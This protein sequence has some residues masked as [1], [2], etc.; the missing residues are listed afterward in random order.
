MT[1]ESSKFYF[2]D[3]EWLYLQS[4]E[5]GQT[6]KAPIKGGV[7]AVIV[8]CKNCSHRWH[9]SEYGKGKL[10]HVIGGVIVACP[11]CETEEQVNL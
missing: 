6:A 7:K 8:V 3:V 9:A 4:Q 2:S 10:L 1:I 5:I 11:S